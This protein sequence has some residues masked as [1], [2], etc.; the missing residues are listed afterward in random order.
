MKIRPETGS[1]RYGMNSSSPRRGKYNGFT[2]VL[3]IA[4]PYYY[5]NEKL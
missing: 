4:I 3:T 5:N 2:V 1:K